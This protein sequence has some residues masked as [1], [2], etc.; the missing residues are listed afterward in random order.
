MRKILVPIDG[1][2]SSMRAVHHAATEARE[3]R[4]LELELLHVLDRT[5]F[6]LPAAS[7]PPDELS[8]VYPQEAAHILEPAARILG[9][10]NIAYR[11]CCRV[12]APAGQIAAQ[13]RESGCQGVIMGTRGLAP[14]QSMLMGSVATRVV[15]LL[16]FPLTL[17]K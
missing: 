2:A 9:E 8:Q 12:G 6:K 13:V 15:E 5:R 14:I 4:K 11:V 10:A 3:N 16:D 7:L 1:S 17:V